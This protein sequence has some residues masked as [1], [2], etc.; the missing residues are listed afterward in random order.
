MQLKEQIVVSKKSKKLTRSTFV[1]DFYHK[2]GKVLDKRFGPISVWAKLHGED[3][4][5][6]KSVKAS[7]KREAKRHAS[8]AGDRLKLNYDYLMSMV[9][10]AVKK[11]EREPGKFE[12]WSFYRAPLQD[13]KKEIQRRKKLSKW[14]F[15]LCVV[16]VVYKYVYVYVCIDVCWLIQWYKNLIL[17]G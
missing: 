4:L 7:S 8:Q 6:M 17:R 3:I 15:F 11:V 10:F 2:K 13:L 16:V 14:V 9:D 1:E 5:I 12:V